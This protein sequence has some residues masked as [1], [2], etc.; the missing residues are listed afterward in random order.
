MLATR[1]G[2][3]NWVEAALIRFF[4][5]LSAHRQA[6]RSVDQRGY[7]PVRRL[8]IDTLK[9]AIASGPRWCTIVAHEETINLLFQW[10]RTRGPDNIL[11]EGENLQMLMDLA[12]EHD[13]FVFVEQVLTRF[14]IDRGWLHPWLRGGN[15]ALDKACMHL[16]SAGPN[17]LKIVDYLSTCDP[18]N[19]VSEYDNEET[20]L[21]RSVAQMDR[22]E[23]AKDIVYLLAKQLL[24]HQY[25]LS[26]GE[27]DVVA[28][29]L[30][31]VPVGIVVKLLENDNLLHFRSVYS[32]ANILHLAVLQQTSELIEAAYDWS[33]KSRPGKGIALINLRN[34]QGVTPLVLAIETRK[35]EHMKAMVG[36]IARTVQ[37]A[38]DE[39]IW[40][41]D[42][43]LDLPDPLGWLDW[44][45]SVLSTAFQVALSRGLCVALRWKTIAK[46]IDNLVDGILMRSAEAGSYLEE[47]QK[48]LQWMEEKRRTSA[49]W[50]DTSILEH[51]HSTNLQVWYDDRTNEFIIWLTRLLDERERAATIQRK[52]QRD[53]PSDQ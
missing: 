50:C 36:F 30:S 49:G 25:N 28:Q 40:T 41:A 39:D 34:R 9:E 51:L 45:E 53:P 11:E 44:L 29:L 3:S 48:L 26:L 10:Y 42:F 2:Q 13:S 31:V 24:D 14:Q 52:Q 32:G 20:P 17:R 38:A 12:I 4:K 5:G 19:L 37:R 46:D 7:D 15:S 6:F 23:V 18:I 47:V 22:A 16:D 33:F 43:P 21:Y 27:E 35:E 1:Y 8:V